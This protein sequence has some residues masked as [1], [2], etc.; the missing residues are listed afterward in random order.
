MKHVFW[1]ICRGA[2]TAAVLLALQPALAQDY[3]AKQIVCIVPTEAGGDGDIL[4]R[5]LFEGVSAR[6]GKP[7][8]VVNKP[9]AAGSAG[10]REIH[11]ARP[12]GY[13]IGLAFP[14]L[15]MNKMQGFLPWDH[16]DFTLIAQH[17]SFTP[18]MVSSAKSAQP[19]KSLKEVI[20]QAKAKPGELKFALSVVG[21]SWWMAGLL[22][23]ANTKT[24]FKNI[25]QE[26]SGAVVIAQLAGGHT[27]VGVSGLAS[28]LSQIEAGNLNF[29]ATFGH[30]RIPGK[31]SNVPTVMESGFDVIW[32]SP[33]FLV[34]PPRMPKNVV[35]KLV[36]AIEAEANRPEFKKAVLNVNA[37]PYYQASE[38]L[39]AYLEKQKEVSRD[40]LQ[41][42]GV[43][44]DNK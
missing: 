30:E 13:T 6:L 41:K 9:G 28:A 2:V 5:A 22:L 42:N 18:I 4:V 38:P 7:I 24:V 14:T 31:F 37:T 10:Y 15:Y 17:G 34:G 16:H 12:D 1:K 43:L 32:D 27:D 21:G 8:V 25:P 40:I 35:E 33:N 19:L 26:G 23:Q 39:M 11:D 36:K 29:I 3:P 44:K 20:A